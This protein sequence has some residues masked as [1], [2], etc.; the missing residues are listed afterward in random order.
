MRSAF[1][2][3]WYPAWRRVDL[4]SEAR[5]HYERIGMVVPRFEERLRCYE[6]RIGVGSLNWYAS[7]GDLVNLDLAARRIVGLL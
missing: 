4:G 3:P 2:T 5:A 7:R 1:W 6:L